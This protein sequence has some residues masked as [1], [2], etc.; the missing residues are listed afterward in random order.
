M[1]YGVTL[2]SI[3]MHFPKNF[4]IFSLFIKKQKKGS[5]CLYV[6]MYTVFFLNMMYAYI[7]RYYHISMKNV[8]RWHIYLRNGIFG[9]MICSWLP[10]IMPKKIGKKGYYKARSICLFGNPFLYSTH[11]SKSLNSDIYFWVLTTSLLSVIL[12]H[13][14]LENKLLFLPWVNKPR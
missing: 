2:T 5:R 4:H 11:S 8:N 9:S 3:V 14:Y 10:S 7:G 6:D 1:Q 12:I 13:R